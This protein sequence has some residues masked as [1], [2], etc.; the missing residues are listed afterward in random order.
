MPNK[1]D[2]DQSPSRPQTAEELPGAFFSCGP[3]STKCRC[4]CSRENRGPCD[5]RWDGAGESILYEDG[6]SMASVSCSR[7]GMLAIDHDIWVL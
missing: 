4:E 2:S 1:P 6:G 7:C 3:S 5:H